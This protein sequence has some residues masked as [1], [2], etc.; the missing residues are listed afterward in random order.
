MKYDKE[1]PAID[2]ADEIRVKSNIDNKKNTNNNKKES[3]DY[4]KVEAR[5]AQIVI[6]SKDE[7]IQ[8][9]ET[10][11][12]M[13][14]NLATVGILSNQYIH[15]TKQAVND[16]GLNLS[17]LLDDLNDGDIK[18]ALIYLEKAQKNIKTLN[19]WFDVS[20]NSIRRDKRK[21]QFINISA[22]ISKQ[23]DSWQDVLYNQNITIIKNF[24]EEINDI[25][26]F[27]YE[28]ESIISNLIA[29]SIT[30]FAGIKGKKIHICLKNAKEGIM[31]QYSDT[32]KGLE[33]GYKKD[34]YR[35]LEAFETSRRNSLG[36]IIGTGLGMWII[37]SIVS[38][39]NGEINLEKN[40]QL[41]NGFFIEIIL[42]STKKGE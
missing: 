42:K 34:P 16:I 36:D 18:D 37:K 40:K 22:L 4:N 13:L 30:A 26:C 41:K 33:R 21:M 9:L 3:N 7:E 11:N 14:R 2:F 20:L 10:E 32:G 27:P 35:I 5:K 15:E 17:V 1:Q 31:L 29:N 23:I 12:K 25:K 24:D 8:N 6:D 19:S 38:D 28:I 39:Y